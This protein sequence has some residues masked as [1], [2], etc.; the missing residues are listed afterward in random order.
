MFLNVKNRAK[1]ALAADLTYPSDW[2]A[3]IAYALGDYVSAT[4]KNGFRYECTTAGTS[5]TAEPTWPT[6]QGATV[7]DNTVVWTCRG[8][9]ANVTAG[10]GAKFPT[11]NFHITID[12]EIL[13]CSSRSTDTLTLEG[14]KEGTTP[15]DHLAGASVELRITAGIFEE[16]RK[17]I[18]EGLD[19]DKPASPE[20]GEVYLATD[21]GK[22]YKCATAGT[23][24]LIGMDLFSKDYYLAST[25][26]GAE[27]VDSS[28][29]NGTGY[30]GTSKNL[31]LIGTGLT[32]GSYQGAYC[33]FGWAQNPNAFT[34]T[35][36][37]RVE[38]LQLVN[39]ANGNTCWLCGNGQPVTTEHYFGFKVVGT[40]VYAVNCNGSAETATDITTQVT[41]NTLIAQTFTVIFTPAVDCKFY[42][43]G[44]LVATHTTNLPTTYGKE[45]ELFIYAANGTD[46]AQNAVYVT[47][48]NYYQSF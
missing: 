36:M 20:V 7:T 21:T 43:N 9:S 25:H 26:L 17:K 29:Q 41:L 32:A 3:S 37:W 34:K 48:F 16:G 19:A 12:D 5:G 2:A 39:T 13:L 44:T 18:P 46:A 24:S 4:T 6:T 47:G 22:V 23:W 45:G 8:L 1:S 27:S 11:E 15:V 28:S 40:T 35:I 10:E 38:T 33:S 14:G 42:V 31:L 30:I